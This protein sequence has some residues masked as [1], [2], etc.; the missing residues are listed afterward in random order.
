[1]LLEISGLTSHYG[2]IQALK[3]IDVQVA[4]GN[5]RTVLCHQNRRGAT[6]IAG[7]A[8]HDDPLAD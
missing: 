7:T 5:R 1:M 3:G 4:D 6:D 8:G 2:R